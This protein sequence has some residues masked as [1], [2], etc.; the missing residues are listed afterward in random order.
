MLQINVPDG[1]DGL[2]VGEVLRRCGVSVTALRKAKHIADGITV[3]GEPVF[4]NAAVRAGMVLC[5]EAPGHISTVTPQNIP[6]NIVFENRDAVVLEK[7]A[8][9]A[10]HPTLNYPDGTL[11]NAWMGELARRAAWQDGN[12]QTAGFFP[13]YRLDKD[14]TGL[15]LCAQ[16]GTVVPFLARSCQKLYAAVLIGAPPFAQGDCHAPIGRAAGSVILRCVE[17]AGQSAYTHWQTVATGEKDGQQYTLV[18]FRLYTGRTHQIRVHMSFLGC[19]LAGDDLYGGQRTEAFPRQ[20]L[21]C[22]G[23][24]FC[25]PDAQ[26]HRFFSRFPDQLLENSGIS[27]LAANRALQAL[28]DAENP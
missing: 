24:S 10:V 1:M 6:L 13:V 4:T 22:I 25:G 3:D 5:V 9:M 16:N 2:T 7:P 23:V 20:A 26:T 11:A 12:P 8:G 27:P 21:H 15:L 28:F 18:V 17:Q 19:P 14:T